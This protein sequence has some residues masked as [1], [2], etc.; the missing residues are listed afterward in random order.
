M[1]HDR[2]GHTAEEKPVESA[3]PLEIFRSVANF[4]VE[5]KGVRHTVPR[6]YRGKLVY[7]MRGIADL[8][9]IPCTVRKPR[10]AMYQPAESRRSGTTRA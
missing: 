6:R 1:A 4:S 2:L 3:P 8:P 5:S 10:T 7:L 9:F